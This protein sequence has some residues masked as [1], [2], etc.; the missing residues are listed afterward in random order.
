MGLDRQG[1]LTPCGEKLENLVHLLEVQKRQI[2]KLREVARWAGVV[3][4]DLEQHGPSIVP[5]LMD[6]DDN[7]GE[8]LRR[9]LRDLGA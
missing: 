8:Y 4:A 2:A 1:I 5:H 3:M 7:D 9:A 6:T